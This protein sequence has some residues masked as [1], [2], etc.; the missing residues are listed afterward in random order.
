METSCQS[1]ITPGLIDSALKLQLILLFH[2][3][4]DYC[5]DTWTVSEWLR[6]N[7]WAI[8]EALE[9]LAEAGFLG[10]GLVSGYTKYHIELSLEHLATL[11]QLVA[12]Y[13]DPLRREQ[14][15]SLVHLADRERR[16][17]ACIRTAELERAY[18]C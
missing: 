1:L 5:G 4:P 10:R 3:H 7:P 9:S 6:E 11:E 15:Y 2:R 18:Y 14:I 16:F 8:E 13:E 17:R 12:C